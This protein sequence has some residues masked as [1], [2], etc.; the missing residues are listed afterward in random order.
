VDAAPVPWHGRN[1]LLNITVPPLGMVAF[2][3]KRG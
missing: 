2:K 1:Y 3:R